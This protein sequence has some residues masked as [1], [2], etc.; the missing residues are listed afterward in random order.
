MSGAPLYGTGA[1]WR[2]PEPAR[3]GSI[4]GGSGWVYRSSTS[5]DALCLKSGLVRSMG[6]HHTGP[7]L[8][9]HFSRWN[10]WARIQ[11]RAEG[12]F[13]EQVAPGAFT[14]T[15]ANNRAGIRCLFQHGRDQATG[16]KPLGPIEELRE[17]DLGGFY[18]VPLLNVDYVNRLIPGLQAGLYGASFRFSVDRQRVNH[19]PVRSEYNP[20]GLPERT[21]QAA[22]VREIGPVTWGAYADATAAV[23]MPAPQMAAAS[24]SRRSAARLRPRQRRPGSWVIR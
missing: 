20:K 16:E 1:W 23:A 18:A 15:F 10:S 14:E 3:G 17:D 22:R 12:D 2:L 5:P 24:S 19:R 6:G 21:I 7:V 9:G 13:F 4:R 8:H 11:S